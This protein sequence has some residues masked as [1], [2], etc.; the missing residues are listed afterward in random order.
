[1]AVATYQTDKVPTQWPVEVTVE[2][3][4]PHHLFELIERLHAGAQI[5]RCEG[6]LQS[7]KWD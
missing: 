3:L 5:A 2:F 1:M 6:L 7:L 4:T